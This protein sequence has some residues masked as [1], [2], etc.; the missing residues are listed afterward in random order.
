M[1]IYINL[2]ITSAFSSLLP[3][4]S[5]IVVFRSCGKIVRY[6]IIF[7]IFSSSTEIVSFFL[8]SIH[9]NNLWLDNIF[10]IAELGFFAKII[11][12]WL[13]KKNI[14]RVINILLLLWI[15]TWVFTSALLLKSIFV[16]NVYTHCFESMI[17]ISLAGMLL[18]KISSEFA[19]NLFLDTRF[20]V[21]SAILIFYSVN[22]VIFGLGKFILSVS[23]D[24]M[25][26]VWVIH[27]VTNIFS[28]ILFSI[29][30]LCNLKRD[31]S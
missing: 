11:G 18:L 16:F 30:F 1:S 6:L 31:R 13:E 29:G 5:G 28:N 4:L 10:I 8:A 19:G 3:T 17:L 20:W 27:S 21:C 22:I 9:K 26:E 12:V 2:A 25:G 23:F 7:F 14:N 24:N 15:L